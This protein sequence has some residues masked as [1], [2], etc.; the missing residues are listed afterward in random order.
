MHNLFFNDFIQVYILY[1]FRI[2]FVSIIPISFM[3]VI[4]A[5]RSIVGPLKKETFQLGLQTTFSNALFLLH[6]L[7]WF[8][9]LLLKRFFGYLAISYIFITSCVSVQRVS[10]VDHFRPFFCLHEPT[11]VGT[12]Q[13]IASKFENLF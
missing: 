5:V 6:E 1:R 10:S 13:S 7:F 8:F 4:W 11:S 12:M 3:F 2:S 9:L